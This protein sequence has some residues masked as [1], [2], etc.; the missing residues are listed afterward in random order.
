MRTNKTIYQIKAIKFDNEYDS[1]YYKI[2][3]VKLQNSYP[4]SSKLERFYSTQENANRSIDAMHNSL[5]IKLMREVQTLKGIKR[6]DGAERYNE[7]TNLLTE[8]FFE[9]VERTVE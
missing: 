7:I 3:S 4:A 8:K 5:T 1:E 2:E 9:I 6:G